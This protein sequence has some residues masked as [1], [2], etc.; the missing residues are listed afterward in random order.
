MTTTTPDF[1]WTVTIH[2]RNGLTFTSE[3]TTLAVAH[4]YFNDAI[5]DGH[6]ASINAPAVL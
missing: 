4:S 3:P 5:A 6:A 2:H 1:G